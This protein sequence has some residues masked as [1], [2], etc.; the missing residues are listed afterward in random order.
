MM[1]ELKQCERCNIV[2]LKTEY[3]RSRDNKCKVC[4]LILRKQYYLDNKHKIIQRVKIYYDKNL[5]GKPKPKARDSLKLKEKNTKYYLENKARL[6]QQQKAYRKAN[7]AMFLAK[8]NKRRASK[9]NACPFWL[10]KEDK[11]EIESFY[12]LAKK[13]ELETGLKYHVDH[14]VPL[15]G[16]FVC[17]LHVPWNLQVILATE[18]MAKSN[19][20]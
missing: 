6:R 12:A 10:T 20:E 15:Q 18:N 14:I 3:Y 11:K 4:T 13:L 19:K 5:K 8:D 1:S 9:I 16:K 7:L 17:G 2:K